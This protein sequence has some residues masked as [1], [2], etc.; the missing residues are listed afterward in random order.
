MYSRSSRRRARP[1]AA[2]ARAR[3]YR[4]SISS[5][6]PL[7][8]TLSRRSSFATPK[9]SRG[10]AGA[11]RYRVASVGRE[12]P[13]Y[14]R[15]GKA[16]PMEA[17]VFDHVSSITSFGAAGTGLVEHLNEIAEGTAINNRLSN[18]CTLRNLLIRG[19]VRANLS[20]QPTSGVLMIVYDRQPQGALPAYT[21]IMDAATVLSYQRLD[22]RDRFQILWR[23]SRIFEPYTTSNSDTTQFLDMNLDLGERECVYAT[24]ATTGTIAD[25]KQ[26]ALY[27]VTVGDQAVLANNFAASIGFRIVFSP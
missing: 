11:T 24:T 4:R 14:L 6:M 17:H 25:C 21:D 26:G 22:S 27:L 7:S 13:L 1:L 23:W 3:R 12:V 10:V 19:Q 8:A 20:T 9:F 15:P 2:R 16:A 18:R 5:R